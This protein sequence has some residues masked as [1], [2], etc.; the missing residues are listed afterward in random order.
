M[1]KHPQPLTS[2]VL[3]A[4]PFFENA[5]R[6][7][8]EAGTR[9]TAAMSSRRRATA[10]TLLVL[11]AICFV[12]GRSTKMML[13]LFKDHEAGC[14]MDIPPLPQLLFIADQSNL[15]R[16]ILRIRGLHRI[17]STWSHF[18]PFPGHTWTAPL[19]ITRRHYSTSLHDA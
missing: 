2:L 7:L 3:P 12:E 19:S 13:L 16:S 1:L 17:L 9:P 11:V 10:A 5:V 14:K 18:A 4:Q 15:T 8:A 6:V